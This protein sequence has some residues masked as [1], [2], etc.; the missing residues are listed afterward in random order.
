MDKPAAPA[1]P[2]AQVY[3]SFL[4]DLALQGAKPSTIHRY[5]YNIVRFEKW[6]N[7][8]G[9]PATGAPAATRMPAIAPAPSTSRQMPR[10]VSYRSIA[11]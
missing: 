1:T 8:N 4:D 7:D 11:T 9:H 2:F 10:V 5:R 3:Q 6:L